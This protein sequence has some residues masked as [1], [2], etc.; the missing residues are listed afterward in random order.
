APPRWPTLRPRLL[1]APL[2]RRAPSVCRPG[3]A[4]R[5]HTFLSPW[6]PRRLLG[7]GLAGA[8]APPPPSSHASGTGAFGQHH[9]APV[10]RAA[11]QVV[12]SVR[13]VPTAPAPARREYRRR[14]PRRG[15]RRGPGRGVPAGGPRG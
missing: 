9:R 7:A 11:P 13:Q 10:L 12:L 6:R 5:R 14:R 15:S 3:A 8:P 4:G 1:L 2:A